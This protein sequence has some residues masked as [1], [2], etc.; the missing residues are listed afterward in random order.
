VF[1]AQ[2][3]FE[4]RSDIWSLGSGR[5]LLKQTAWIVGRSGV[6][7]WLLTFLLVSCDGLVSAE[8]IPPVKHCSSDSQQVW[9]QTVFEDRLGHL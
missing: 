9:K 4:R 7:H 2:K 6:D 5:Q 1:A 3:A 8:P